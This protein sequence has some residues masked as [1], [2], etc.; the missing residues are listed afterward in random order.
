MKVFA[1]NLTEI[2]GSEIAAKL[3]GIAGGLENLA[4]LPSSTLFLLGKQKKSLM[5]FS[6]STTISHHGYGNFAFLC[7]FSL[8]SLENVTS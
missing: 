5:G 3:I 7:N 4:K 8:G 1:P 6:T 2:V